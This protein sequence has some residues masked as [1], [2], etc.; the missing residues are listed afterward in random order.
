MSE[1]QPLTGPF[2]FQLTVHSLL[3]TYLAPIPAGFPSPAEDYLM[4][5][6]DFNELLLNPPE[7]TFGFFVRGESMA[8]AGI[9]TNDILVVNTEAE[10]QL[11]QI[12]VA[13]VNGDWAVKTLGAVGGS[14]ALISHNPDYAP[15]L[16]KEFDE[17]V[18]FGVVRGFVR[19]FQRGKP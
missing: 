16:L 3:K 12:V 4:R 9:H 19:L 1:T 17:L 18:I 5:E 15:I 2:R 6:L 11:G 14:P 10:R 7:S 8:E 13:G